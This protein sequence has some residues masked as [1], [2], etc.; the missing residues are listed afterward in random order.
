MSVPALPDIELLIPHRGKM[1][2]IERVVLVEGDTIV[3]AAVVPENGL[4][5][6]TDDRPPGYLVIEM[7]AQTVSAWDGWQRYAYGAPPTIG[8]LLGT[9][10]FRCNRA[11]L[12]P[13]ET[14]QIRATVSVSGDEM[15]SFD[16]EARDQEGLSQPSS[17][18]FA[19]GTLSVFRPTAD[20][21]RADQ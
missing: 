6:L 20:V 5:D 11:L 9:R 19:A 1:R 7:M 2:L 16:C 13:G 15:A 18:P 14:L 10:R 12:Q 4:F 8:F 21:A 3:A 17:E